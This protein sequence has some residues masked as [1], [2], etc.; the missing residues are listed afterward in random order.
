LH[1]AGR[2]PTDKTHPSNAQRPQFEGELMRDC[3]RR[4]EGKSAT[5]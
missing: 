4:L 3:L 2:I 5:A 1:L